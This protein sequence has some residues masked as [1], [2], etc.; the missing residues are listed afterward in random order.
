MGFFDRWMNGRF[1]SNASSIIAELTIERQKYLLEEMDLSFSQSLD[2]KMRP[3]SPVQGSLVSLTLSDIPDQEIIRW[4]SNSHV[5]KNGHVRFYLNSKLL[6]E[7]T[8]MTLIFNNA[9]CVKYRKEIIQ[10]GGR[11]LTTLIIAPTSIQI[12]DV[13]FEW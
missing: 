6:E 4:L 9:T 7:G 12:G 10:G 2:H 8:Q 11:I 1:E 5:R 13:L 3:D